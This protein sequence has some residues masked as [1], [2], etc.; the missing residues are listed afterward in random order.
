MML[1]MAL[2]FFIIAII[3]GVFGFGGL[4]ATAT[5]IAVFL[6]YIFVALFIIS[7]LFSLIDRRNL[8]PPV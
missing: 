2:M 8:P 5:D 7:L 1:R 4:A 3:A 6:F